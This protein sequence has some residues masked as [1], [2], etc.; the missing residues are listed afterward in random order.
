MTF[1]L[2]VPSVHAIKNALEAISGAVK[3]EPLPER[4]RLG[5]D[6]ASEIWRFDPESVADSAYGETLNPVDTQ[7][8]AGDDSEG[9]LS[10]EPTVVFEVPP[11]ITD[12]DVKNV[13]GDGLG[14]LERLQQI[15]GIDALGWYV[16]FHQRRFQHGVYIPVEGVVAL[17][18]GAL[19][20]L[21]VPLARRLELAFHAILRHEIFHFAV[22]CMAANWELVIGAEVYWKAK[23]CHRNANQY[24]ELE[25]ALANAYMLRGFRHPVRA[26]ANS[27]GASTALRRYCHRQPAG[28]CD[29]PRYAASRLS[30]VSGCRELSARF[31]HASANAGKW[32]VPE[33]LDSLL[34]Y[35]DPIRIDGTRCPIVVSDRFGLIKLLGI[36]ASFFRTVMGVVE[37]AEFLRALAKLGSRFE[38]LWER[39]KWDLA[40]SVALASLDFK[41]W[42]PGGPN[43]YSVRIDGNYRAHLHHDRQAGRWLAV[44]IGPHKAMGHG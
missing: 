18:L 25:E 43:T 9:R 14:E 11:E 41:E 17:T 30:Y 31:Q 27:P 37:T 2:N 5:T 1:S 28:Y 16:T 12:A 26:L 24:I 44:A 19:S 15:H 13:L 40:R 8:A 42:K 4:V 35:A 21:K 33:A 7:E 3:D 10:D 39:R 36:R 32:S 29:G 20:R 22:D 6:P 38:K 23:H 34:L